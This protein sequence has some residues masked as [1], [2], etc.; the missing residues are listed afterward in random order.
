MTKTS[1]TERTSVTFPKG[2]LARAHAVGINVSGVSS[3]AVVEA[4]QKMEAQR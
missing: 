2:T 1:K 4:I 3:K